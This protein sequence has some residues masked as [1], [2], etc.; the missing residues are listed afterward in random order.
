[1]WICGF[2]GLGAYWGGAMMFI[3]PSGAVWGME[4]ILPHMQCLPY[5]EQLFSNFIFSGVM[6]ILINGVCNTVATV[7]LI[8]RKLYGVIC[9][10]ASGVMLL[11]WLA[12]QW[13]IFAVNPLTTLYTAIGIVQLWLAIQILRKIRAMCPTD[14]TAVSVHTA[15]PKVTR[16]EQC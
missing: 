1:M 13:V 6:L 9:A 4:A 5:S 8:K 16:D 14:H 15:S 12:V 11:L 10:A 7:G 3:S 2:V